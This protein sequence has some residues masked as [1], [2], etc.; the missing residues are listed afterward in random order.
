MILKASSAVVVSDGGQGGADDNTDNGA[1]LAM[2]VAVA[3]VVDGA[4]GS[5]V[6]LHYQFTHILL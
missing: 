3:S 1:A 2:A 6:N 4:I 5:G